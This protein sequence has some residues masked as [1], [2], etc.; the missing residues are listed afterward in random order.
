MKLREEESVERD[1]SPEFIQN[2][3]NSVANPYVDV[4]D[5]TACSPPPPSGTGEYENERFLKTVMKVPPK[6]PRRTMKNKQKSTTVT[7]HLPSTCD[8]KKDSD[9]PS[10][11]P[12]LPLYSKV[13]IGY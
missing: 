3:R 10:T 7:N 2:K 1:M 11:S 9:I 5:L 6:K 12:N 8:G 4:N 13:S